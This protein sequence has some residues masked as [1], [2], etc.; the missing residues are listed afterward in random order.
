MKMTATFLCAMAL[1]ALPV[2]AMAQ[3][4]SELPL[5]DEG[6]YLSFSAGVTAL[7]DRSINVPAGH[8]T[9]ASKNGMTLIASG[10]HDYGPVWP[11][12]NVRV[13]LALGYRNNEV[14]QQY[15]PGETAL[16]RPFGHTQV[17]SLMYNVI[18]DFRPHTGF[19][20]YIGIGIGYASVDFDRYRARV[21]GESTTFVDDRSGEF[22]YQGMIGFRSRLSPRLD[23]DVSL[24]YFATADPNITTE[25]GDEMETTYR[26]SAALVGL[27]YTF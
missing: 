18:N 16:P 27:T 17:W 12:G 10:G 26:S 11:L 23:L 7:H 21:G 8:V 6:S 19:D 13:E 24:R 5:F 20:P 2:A 22:A 3:N 14:D 4:A 15:L 25:A 1:S 9:T